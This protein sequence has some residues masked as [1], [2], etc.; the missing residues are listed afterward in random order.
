MAKRTPA[1]FLG[2][3]YSE[4]SGVMSLNRALS[5]VSNFG[6]ITVN[7]GDSYNVA[8]SLTEIMLVGYN[9]ILPADRPT[10]WS[11]IKSPFLGSEPGRGRQTYQITFFQTIQPG[12]VQITPDTQG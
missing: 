2:N 4:A 1:Q 12:L 9:N 11:I 8:Y 3:I 7:G 5:H 10:N 6:N